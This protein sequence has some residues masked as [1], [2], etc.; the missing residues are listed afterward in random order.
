MGEQTQFNSG[1]PDTTS[2][3]QVLFSPIVQNYCDPAAII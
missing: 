3:C 2:A 1:G